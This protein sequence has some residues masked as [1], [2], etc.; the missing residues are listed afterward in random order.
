MNKPKW[1]CK[2]SKILETNILKL[3]E[4]WGEKNLWNMKVMILSVLTGMFGMVQR[5][6]QE[7]WNYLI[8]EEKLMPSRL[9]KSLK[10]LR[11]MTY[12]DLLPLDR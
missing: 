8:S 12:W 7:D 4:N 11:S 9:L 10:I 3:S 5:V 1:N 6:L 2:K